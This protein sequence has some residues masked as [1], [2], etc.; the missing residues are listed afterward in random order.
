MVGRNRFFFRTSNHP[1]S[2]GGGLEAWKGYFSSV[3]PTHNQLMANVNGVSQLLLPVTR[4]LSLINTDS[5]QHRLL[6]ARK[7]GDI[8]DSLRLQSA[9]VCQ[10]YQGED[11]PS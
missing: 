5:M 8:D 10:R 11:D 4:R 3:R 7:S 6:Y 2:L 9:S 1:V